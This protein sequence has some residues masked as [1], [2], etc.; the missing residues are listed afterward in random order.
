MGVGPDV[1]GGINC[2][3]LSNE[4]LHSI[5]KKATDIELPDVLI[6]DNALYVERYGEKL[7]D[8]WPEAQDVWK[9]LLTKGTTTSIYHQVVIPL[10]IGSITVR[11][12]ENRFMLIYSNDPKDFIQLKEKKVVT[13]FFN[14]TVTY[15]YT[16]C[17]TDFDKKVVK[18]ITKT[19][20]MDGII[21]EPKIMK[22][23]FNSYDSDG[24]YDASLDEEFVFDKPK[25]FDKQLTNYIPYLGLRYYITV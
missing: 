6:A 23:N 19:A 25:L 22:K 1:V 12:Y 9:N 24:R 11:R 2:Y 7:F 10:R 4:M 15:V 8:F 5:I 17:L 13:G 14:K 3:H 21:V 20:G 16:P 18:D